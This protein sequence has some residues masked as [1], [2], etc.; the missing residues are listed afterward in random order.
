MRGGDRRKS[1]RLTLKRGLAPCHEQL[2]VLRPGP[3]LPRAALP[4]SRPTCDG[5]VSSTVHLSSLPLGFS[6]VFLAVLC[7]FRGKGWGVFAARP[8]VEPGPPL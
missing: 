5:L 8:G 6:F 7:G 4:Q 2:T 3:L 1:L